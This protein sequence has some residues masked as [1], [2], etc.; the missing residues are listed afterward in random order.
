[1]FGI[2][3]LVS[4]ATVDYEKRISDL[5]SPEEAKEDVESGDVI[6]YTVG[7]IAAFP[8]GLE[9]IQRKL[10]SDY[11]TQYLGPVV[12]SNVYHLAALYNAEIFNQLLLLE[13]GKYIVISGDTFARIAQKF[14]LDIA[15][16]IEM[17]PDID[18]RRLQIG[19]VLTVSKET[20]TSR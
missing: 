6:F 3:F 20:I 8:V 14:S 9:D 11:P 15:D 18:P 10:I 17:N 1:M 12:P 19:D 16:L 13:Q 7:D 5:R 4:C 2:A